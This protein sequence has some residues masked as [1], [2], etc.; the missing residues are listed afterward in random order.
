[1]RF[2]KVAVLSL[3]FALLAVALMLPASFAG[4]PTIAPPC[5]QCH[6]EAPDVVRGTLVGVSE[7]FR[8]IQV[9][10]GKLVWVITYGDDLKLIGAEKL[11]AIPKDKEVA[12]AFVEKEGQKPFATSLSVK[13]PAKVPAEK[14]ITV[15][16]MAELV[17]KGPEKGKYT[18]I[19]SRP[20][21]R[22]IEGH[23]P[24]ALNLP[25]DKFDELKDKVLPKDK[26]AL[27]IFYCAGVT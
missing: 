5:K 17:A 9:A 24:G 2:G 18:L 6:Q 23:I 15:Q 12:V 4:K 27:V 25:L 20:R 19:D 22:Y 8:T 26:D 7:K 3:I 10:T 1:M 21:P 16:E 13:P 14:L 11:S